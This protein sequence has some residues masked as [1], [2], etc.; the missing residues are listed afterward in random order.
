MNY[1]ALTDGASASPVTLGLLSSMAM[2]P[3]TGI[4]FMY[5]N[6]L[7]VDVS[8]PQASCLG[9]LKNPYQIPNSMK[10]ITYS[11]YYLFE[12]INNLI[13]LED[14]HSIFSNLYERVL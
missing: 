1:P 11:S 8:P 2:L 13:I 6:M 5:S 9:Y 3:F 12:E 4:H 7:L 10:G 14:M